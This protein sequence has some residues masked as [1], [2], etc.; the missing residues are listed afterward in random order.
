MSNTD[1]IQLAR[2]LGR[3]SYRDGHGA[4]T[5]VTNAIAAHPELRAHVDDIREGWRSE[6]SEAV[7][8]AREAL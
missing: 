1:T 5:A 2:G 4:H 8:S 6:R 3:Q 7:E